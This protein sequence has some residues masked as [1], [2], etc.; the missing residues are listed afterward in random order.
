[1]SKA[2]IEVKDEDFLSTLL[3]EGK[4]S[5]VDFWATWCMPCKR[6]EEV[7]EE[8]AGIYGG[9]ISFLKVDVEEYSSVASRY[10]VRSVPTLLFFQQGEVVDQMVGTV[11]KEAIE[12][13]LRNMLSDA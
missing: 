11:S 10:A 1:M 7:L 6:L 2:I 3:A 13:K 12:E 5:V 9:K 8:I 4:P